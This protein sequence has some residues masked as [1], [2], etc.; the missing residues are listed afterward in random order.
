MASTQF[1]LFTLG[2]GSAKPAPPHQ[3]S[4]TVLAIR[5]NLYMIDCGENAQSSFAALRL[6]R[7]RLSHIFITHLHGDHVYGLPG[8][9][10]T[11][12]L[13]G[14]TQEI[15][16]H[17]FREGADIL[18]RIFKFFSPNLPLKISFNIIEY[19]DAHI[20]DDDNVSVCTVALDHRIPDVGFIFEERE[21]PRHIIPEMIDRYAIPYSEINNIKRGADFHTPEGI[22]IPNAELTTP[23]APPVSYAHISDTAYIPD[24][25]QRIGPVDLLM[26][27]TTYLNDREKD[28]AARG[29]STAAQAAMTAR[30]AGAKALLTGHYSS[31]YR[32]LLPFLKEA[33]EIF[34][35]V[36]LNKELLTL[37]LPL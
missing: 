5:N 14:C 27:E 28:A 10:D 4:S 30:D 1:T 2:C 6:K 7:T 36:I 35:N 16:I 24:L 13:S 18:Y 32:D 11:L 25:A 26:H 22:I 37:S 23:P 19:A 33:R 9:I 34:P 3:P 8:L 20:F 15:T 31:S 17:T 21:H 29:H 12:A